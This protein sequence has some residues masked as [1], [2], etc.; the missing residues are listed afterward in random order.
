MCHRSSPDAQGIVHA[1]MQ[2]V[3][4][5]VVREGY[6]QLQDS[7]DN[8]ELMQKGRNEIKSPKRV[9]SWVDR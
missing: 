4:S 6:Y 3:P 2:I 7:P 8:A 1:I 5:H 9:W